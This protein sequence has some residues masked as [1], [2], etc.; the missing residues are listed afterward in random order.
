MKYQ[1]TRRAVLASATAMASLGRAKA[2][3]DADVIV[4]GAGLSGLQAAQILEDAGLTVTVLEANNR[5]GGRVRTLLDKPETPESGGSEVGPMYAR[6]IDQAER[7]GLELR[8]WQAEKLEFAL[9][10]GGEL[11]HLKDWPASKQNMLPETLRKVPP[12]GLSS[13]LLPKDTGLK[14]LDS[15]LEESRGAPDPSLDEYYRSK[16]ADDAAMKLLARLG[17][18]DSPKDESLQFVLHSQKIVEW[19]RGHGPF[20]H[21]VGGMS[22]VPLAM[23]GALQGGVMMNMAV[24]AIATSD[25]GVSV[26]CANGKKFRAKFAICTMPAS[27][28]RDVKLAPALPA[29]QAEAV[30]RIPYAQAT[31]IFFAIKEKFWEADGFASSLWTD[32]DAGRVFNWFVPNGNY[33]WMYIS[34]AANKPLRAMAEKDVIAYATTQLHAARPS[35]KGRVEPI[36]AVNWSANPW[37]KGT[38]AYRAPGQIA[39]YGNIAAAPHGRIHFAGE[40]TAVLQ[41]GLEAAMESGERAALEVLGRI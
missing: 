24:K 37:S 35:A 23:A 19:G 17:Q 34:G 41:A 28:L 40:H 27:V 2:A 16:G 39:A 15:W 5:V 38:F 32:G 3:D 25:T 31:S 8:P 1:L 7:F 33:V 14:E 10:I 20:R 22:K 18:A 13:V 21:V 30:A 29:L 26:T 11:M 6:V 36:A 9:N 12:M 4:I